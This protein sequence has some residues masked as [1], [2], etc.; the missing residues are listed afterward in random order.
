LRDWSPGSAGSH[1]SAR[2]PHCPLGPIVL[3][4]SLQVAFAVPNF[5]IQEQG[6]RMHYNTGGDLLDY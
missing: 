6:L 5:L 3:A 1:P 4:A 2:S